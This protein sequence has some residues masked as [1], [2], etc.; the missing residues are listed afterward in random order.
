MGLSCPAI[1]VKAI[2][3]GRVITEQVDYSKK[4]LPFTPFL[5]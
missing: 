1:Y 2:L 5:L 3:K 4:S